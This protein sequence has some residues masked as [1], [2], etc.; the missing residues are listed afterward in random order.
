MSSSFAGEFGSSF[1]PV[2]KGAA[3]MLPLGVDIFKL[4]RG[5]YL[6]VIVCS[7]LVFKVHLCEVCLVTLIEDVSVG[8]PGPE[9]ASDA[10]RNFKIFRFPFPRLLGIVVRMLRRY[11]Y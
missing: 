3:T 9:T 2:L 4:S 10:Q 8:K 1:L 5:G 11:K 7:G 6:E